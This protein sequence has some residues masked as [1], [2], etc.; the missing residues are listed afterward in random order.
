[1]NDFFI[2]DF[3]SVDAE[4]GNVC[5]EGRHNAT[6]TKIE[7][8]T[9]KAGRPMMVVEWTIDGGEG[10]GHTVVDYI[11][12]GLRGF[13]G[14]ARLKRI[15]VASGFRWQ[16]RGDHLAAFEFEDDWIDIGSP[17]SLNLARGTGA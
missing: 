3:D 9:S 5:P 4:G 11:T 2:P 7:A 8:E 15:C 10:A 6:A 12:F 13:F 1:M 17:S 16:Q 14:E